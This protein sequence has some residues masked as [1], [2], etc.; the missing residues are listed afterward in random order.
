LG[1]LEGKVVLVT[2]GTSGIGEA[3]CR[4]FAEEGA[5]VAVIGRDHGRGQQLVSEIGKS[6]GQALF[7]SADLRRKEEIELVVTRT[8]EDL[9]QIDILVNSAGVALS[10]RLVDLSEVEWDDVMSINLKAAYLA[11]KAVLHQ[12]IPRQSGVIINIGSNAV[13]PFPGG[14]AYSASKAG[15][16][17]LTKVIALEYASSNIRSNC[18]N[19]GIIDTPMFTR[20]F[21]GLANP[22]HA[23]KATIDRVP[24]G[25]PGRPEEVAKLALYLAS[26]EGSYITGAAIVVDGGTTAGRMVGRLIS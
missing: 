17:A 23:R 15:L 8:R 5:S 21:D 25:R 20:Q 9:G 19:P 6:G 3:V 7:F 14:A 2:G 13:T 24:L 18:I 26:E 10:K 1:K 11:C 16:Q 12:M 4:L 22:Q